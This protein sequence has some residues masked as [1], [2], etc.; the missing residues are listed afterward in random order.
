MAKIN[1]SQFMSEVKDII[2]ESLNNENSKRNSTENIFN[3]KKSINYLVENCSNNADLLSYLN[4]Y[5]KL[6]NNGTSDILLFENYL[7]DLSK[8]KNNRIVNEE[9]NKLSHI[10]QEH[11]T[12]FAALYLL[13]NVSNE[14]AK[15]LIELP[16]MNYINDQSLENK[17]I[18]I[19][20]L[21]SASIFNDPNI[22]KIN[23]ILNEGELRNT[24][25]FI[26]SPIIGSR[27]NE[28]EEISNFNIEKLKNIN[29]EIK[30]KEILEKVNNLINN[31]LNEQKEE[32][33]KFTLDSLIKSSKLN[34]VESITH[35]YNSEAA[36][37]K[38]LMSIVNQYSN[39]IAQ[40]AYQARLYESF[41]QNLKNFSYLLPVEKEINS[42]TECVKSDGDIKTSLT[43][44]LEEMK[45]STSYYLVP[46][47]EEDVVRYA[48]DPTPI[49]RVQL[50]NCLAP[51]GADPY[52]TAIY[53]YVYL[54]ENKDHNL[55][56]EAKDSQEFLK[57]NVSIKNIYS[58]VQYIKENESV[59]N[60]NNVFYTKKGSQINKL[61]ENNYSSLPKS[62]I[63]LSKLV[64]D[65]RVE[66]Y[67]DHIELNYSSDAYAKIF[68]GYVDINGNKEDKVSLRNLNEMFMKYDNY[69]QNFYI[70][71]SCLLENF[72]NIANIDFAKHIEL[73]ENKEISLDLIK[74]NNSLYISSNNVLGQHTFY[75]NVNPIQC[76]NII[77]EH[78]GMNVSNLFEDILPNQ[79]KILNTLNETK[80]EYEMAIEK[81]ES[82][83]S[84]LNSTKENTK[85]DK[86]L[87]KLEKTISSTKEKLD[88]IKNEYKEWQKEADKVS[89][90]KSDKENILND[91]PSADDSKETTNSPIDKKEIK[92]VKDELSKPIS[93]DEI[94]STIE[95]PLSKKDEIE[96]IEKQEDIKD[97]E[98][99]TF[100]KDNNTIE[101]E[102]NSD[103][104]DEFQDA[105]KY[106]LDS[107]E[108]ITDDYDN[109]VD[110]TTNKPNYIVSFHKNIKTGEKE[111]N[112]VVTV[113]IPMIS[114]E[115]NT[116][117]ENSIVNFY[118]DS[119]NEP[120]LNN[121]DMPEGLYKDIVN[122]IKN[123]INYSEYAAIKEP[124]KN[125]N[126]DS[127]LAYDED[128]TSFELPA[129]NIDHSEIKESILNINPEIK[130]K[131]GKK[132]ILNENSATEVKDFNEYAKINSKEEKEAEENEKSVED[133][134]L[135]DSNIDPKNAIETLYNAAVKTADE[136]N[137]NLE[138]EYS[139]DT[140]EYS[141]EENEEINHI[142]IGEI[143]EYEDPEVEKTVYTFVI[144]QG[145]EE[146]EE[147]EE[148]DESMWKDLSNDAKVMAT[149]ESAEPNKEIEITNSKSYNI[150]VIDNKMYEPIESEEFNNILSKFYDDENDKY[151]FSG[152]VNALSFDNDE[153]REYVIT[154]NIKDCAFYLSSVFSSMTGKTYEINLENNEEDKENEEENS[155]VYENVKIRKKFSN[156]NNFEKSIKNDEIFHGDEED[157]KQEKR[158]NSI[159]N[160]KG[161]NSL[162]N[163]Q[164]NNQMGFSESYSPKMNTFHLSEVNEDKKIEKGTI[165][166]GDNVMFNNLRAQV[167]AIK[168][169]GTCTIIAQGMT[170][171]TTVKQLK[172]LDNK[173]LYTIKQFNFD[174]NK[175]TP[176]EPSDNETAKDGHHNDLNGKVI[177]V[178][179]VVDG[180]KLNIKECYASLY[181]I[182]KNKENIRVIN[183]DGHVDYY[184]PE[185]IE[186][187]EL[188]Q[189]DWPWA[190]LTTDDEGEPQRK[191][192]VNP[193]SFINCEDEDNNVECLVADKLS[194][195][196][197][198]I[199][200]IIS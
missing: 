17:N 51:F 79:N 74:V 159:T 54:D 158:I 175:L 131:N 103:Y 116:Y 41:V 13:E 137:V 182:M 98:P 53:N 110:N 87:E 157:K 39:A 172:R 148:V 112:G 47:I 66:I 35:L 40:G 59:F 28:N 77:N 43:K 119:N 8:F 166:P 82:M 199:I 141:Q 22:N 73:N 118:L 95:K 153:E 143:S 195:I 34:L 30:T 139:D 152:L 149:K 11:Q 168:P 179:L 9:I 14:N 167:I 75:R 52:V 177:P 198:K 5:N 85:D 18:L 69:D 191:I 25:P 88:H 194:Y 78:M 3:L 133:E 80:E 37:N 96:D 134:D 162:N 124:E 67:E 187:I 123:D 147:A 83:L 93:D 50:R 32:K 113:I 181:D 94:S 19:E 170:I 150:Y 127:I 161:Q 48:M 65:P 27:M 31:K 117:T 61:N 155:D 165:E 46:L 6:L 145:A 176:I 107:D 135:I 72:N 104:Y 1:K 7:N 57:Q 121:D 184:E 102:N 169:D 109:I 151:N 4:Q 144:S 105:L 185:N 29:K 62:F 189:E 63:E 33:S 12:E 100:D 90:A 192:K 91:E 2:N 120:I 42:I 76:R 86:D 81:Y 130:T 125:N 186:V 129:P 45:E 64:N 174:D 180:Y 171:D 160:G 193:Q 200:K 101:N 44:I 138:D 128:G 20:S 23:I 156:E 49:N 188:N 146:A 99:V 26:A 142:E 178:N 136:V 68:E 15:S 36:S 114:P 115:G 89:N 55:V 71:C 92:N 132:Y 21:E 24:T 106:S 122:T 38:K 70:M 197:K 97:I 154:N 16:L 173:D 111:R 140:D 58:P 10:I 164:N 196:P 190:I 60:I 183:E 163:G 108:D 126:E 56:F 84:K